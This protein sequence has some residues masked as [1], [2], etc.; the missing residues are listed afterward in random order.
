MAGPGLEHDRLK[1]VLLHGGLEVAMR[2]A[3]I[4]SLGHGG[5]PNGWSMAGLCFVNIFAPQSVMYMQSSRRTPN[6]P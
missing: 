4:G 6:S 1:A 2:S 5:Y 3:I